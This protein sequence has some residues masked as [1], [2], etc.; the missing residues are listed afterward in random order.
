M[1]T[2]LFPTKSYQIHKHF[3]GFIREHTC[4]CQV[5]PG[6]AHAWTAPVQKKQSLNAYLPIAFVEIVPMPVAL[7]GNSHIPISWQFNSPHLKMDALVERS[8]SIVHAPT[9]SI[10]VNQATPYK[11][12]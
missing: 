2:K 5:Q 4:P 7:E 6:L 12:I 8:L 1:S 10:H 9:L 3:E 11:H